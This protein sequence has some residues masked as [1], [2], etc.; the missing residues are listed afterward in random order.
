MINKRPDCCNTSFMLIDTVYSSLSPSKQFPSLAT[1]HSQRFCQLWNAFWN[2]SFG[3]A[4]NSFVEFFWISSNVSKRRLF[5][6]VCIYVITDSS[7]LRSGGFCCCAIRKFCVQYKAVY[8]L[9]PERLLTT[10]EQFWNMH[11]VD[12]HE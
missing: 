12:G 2:A 5:F 11:L 9:N 7:D 10:H 8:F 6:T 4:N 1:H 3:M